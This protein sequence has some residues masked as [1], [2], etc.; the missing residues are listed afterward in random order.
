LYNEG[1]L[2]DIFCVLGGQ[3]KKL[4]L[5]AIA[6][7]VGT[8][9]YASQSSQLASITSAFK[10]SPHEKPKIDPNDVMMGYAGEDI[11][12]RLVIVPRTATA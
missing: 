6:T 5:I 7:V 8:C 2:V 1:Y 3:M 4:I 12:H 11:Y 9:A 10:T